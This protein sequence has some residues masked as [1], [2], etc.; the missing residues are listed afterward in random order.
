MFN[1]LVYLREVLTEL[2]QVTWPTPRQTTNKTL[3]VIVVSTVIAL[4]IAVLDAAI[5]RAIGFLIQ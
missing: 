5:Q 3:L 4:Y 2:R 1:P